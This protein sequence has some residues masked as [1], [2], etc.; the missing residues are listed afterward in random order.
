MSEIP[1]VAPVSLSDEQLQR[2]LELL[3]LRTG[4]CLAQHPLILRQSLVAHFRALGVDDADAYLE[5]VRNSSEGELE[6]SWLAGVIAIK[7]TRFFRDPDAFALV[8]QFV[9]RHAGKLRELDMWS[10]G[11]ATGEEA[12]SL[13]MAAMESMDMLGMHSYLTVT[14]LDI[15]PEALGI[16]RAGLYPARKLEDVAPGLVDKYFIRRDGEFEVVPRVRSRVCFARGNMLELE[17]SPA[18]SMDVVFCQNVLVYFRRERQYR[19]LDALVDRLKLGG[20]LV[21]GP[22]EGAGWNNPLVRRMASSE[23]H[24]YERVH[25]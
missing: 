9:R 6:W 16:A 18:L 10:V 12:Y 22:S 17:R 11:C 24:A 23:V 2:W 15:S 25:H 5:R 14:G 20:I 4:I 21:I 7:E 1:Q 3:E 19:V 8:Q 13:A